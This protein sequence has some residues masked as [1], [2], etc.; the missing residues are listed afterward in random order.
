MM[1]SC[2]NY[3]HAMLF[4]THVQAYVMDH[5][6]D[7]GERVVHTEWLVIPSQIPHYLSDI[8]QTSYL[9]RYAS[10]GYASHASHAGTR[11]KNVEKDWMQRWWHRHPAYANPNAF[12]VF[13]KHAG[14]RP[15]IYDIQVSEH[16]SV[17][18]GVLSPSELNAWVR[19]VKQ[20]LQ[21]YLEVPIRGWPH[22]WG[23]AWLSAYHRRHLA[24]CSEQSRIQ[25]LI[26]MDRPLASMTRA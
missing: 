16:H 14:D 23:E 18:Y 17:K 21:S 26:P 2:W 5:G 1:A 15:T 20:T 7:G 4:E 6:N 9:Y 10:Y 12:V 3:L 24:Y 11:K 25:N 22:Q 8:V 19:R 13:L